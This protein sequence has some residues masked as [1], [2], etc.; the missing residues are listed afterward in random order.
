MWKTRLRQNVSLLFAIAVACMALTGTASAQG[1]NARTYYATITT[2]GSAAPNEEKAYTLT[3]S[4]WSQNLCPTCTP[5][6]FIQQIKVTLPPDFTL[7]TPQGESGPVTSI[8]SNWQYSVSSGSPQVIT[9]VTK[10]STDASLVVG[11]SVPF[12]IWAKYTRTL[13][14]G[15]NSTLSAQWKMY[16]N[17]SVSGGA[18][19]TFSLPKGTSYPTVTIASSDCVIP[20]ALDLTLTPSTIKT[21]ATNATVILSATLKSAVTNAVIP[22]EPI[23]FTLAGAPLSACS[24]VPTDG[25]GVATCSFMPQQ[26][27]TPLVAGTYSLQANFAGDTVPTPDWDASWST[28]RYLTVNTDG[29]GLTVDDASGTYEGTVTLS[30]HLTSNN[31][32]LSG[33]RIDFYINNTYK[34]FATTDSFGIASLPSVSIAEIAA[35]PHPGYIL[36]RFVGDSTYSATSGSS[37]L[38]VSQQSVTIDW[39][40]PT[41]IVYGTT[42]SETQLNAAASVSG[43]FVYTPSAGT[44][45][46]AG[47]QELSVTFTPS[48]TTNYPTESKT[49]YINVL[50]ANQTITFGSLGNK[51]YGVADFT[52]TASASPS[53]LPVSFT[54]SGQCTVSTGTVHLTGAGS[55]TITATQAGNNNYSAATAVPQS[56]TIGTA[57]LTITADA[58][59]NTAAIDAFTKVYGADNPAFAA[60]YAGFVNG[61]NTSVLTGTLAFTTSA[62]ATSAV[63]NYAV[64]PAGQSS[65]NYTITYVA[66]TLTVTQASQSITFGALG[67]KTY[68]DADF[69][70]TASASPS[71]LPVSFTASGQCTVST[72]TVHLTG[73]GSCT[74]TASQG[75]D[76]NYSPAVPVSRSF[77]V[78]T[79]QSI[80]FTSFTITAEA[81]SGLAITF[82]SADTTVCTVGPSVQN[83]Q[84][85]TKWSTT[86]TLLAGK[87]WVECKVTADQSG[88]AEYNSASPATAILGTA[89]SQ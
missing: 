51:T 2:T 64:T 61:D 20:T 57:A 70:V 13:P 36:A 1:S 25:D 67:N 32:D 83:D 24:A 38:N 7:V 55:C 48:D 86:A 82:S 59:I 47:S 41:E 33:K 6:H 4:N 15:C 56:F 72:G 23:T 21:T 88:N 77:T 81:T 9:F 28:A 5:L 65:N 45:L 52:V 80:A 44:L 3:V 79:S 54:A 73:A 58:D 18:G 37:N 87:S 14:G 60:R 75:G 68:G 42:L 78:R 19:N 40:N 39:S 29:T 22:G 62:T 26:T 17:Q 76:I 35:G 46:D 10:S 34:D 49:V 69:T 85:P 74:I 89:Q 8:P 50:K 66:G 16:V 84:E 30:A 12:V 53:G 43:T 27:N 11:Q 31:A 71:G 63:G